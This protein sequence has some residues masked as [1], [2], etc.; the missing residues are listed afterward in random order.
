[1]AN[2]KYKFGAGLVIGIVCAAV[3]FLYFAPRYQITKSGSMLYRQDCWSGD[4]WRFIDNGWKKVQQKD[5]DWNSIDQ[6]LR[7]A[8]NIP[9]SSKERKT[10]LLEL[11]KN[12]STLNILS[13]E[14]ILERIKIVYARE[15]LGNLYL[16]N[17]LKI[18]NKKNPVKK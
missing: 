7:K 4:T 8:L 10:A 11:K 6:A 9:E 2:G 12:Y 14:E 5:R 17:Y 15:I 1:M 18:Q 3:F 16:E 13:D